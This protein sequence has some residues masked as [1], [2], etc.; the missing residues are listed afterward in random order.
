MKILV[1]RCV[2]VFQFYAQALCLR[3]SIYKPAAGIVCM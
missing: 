3:V 2:L 1:M